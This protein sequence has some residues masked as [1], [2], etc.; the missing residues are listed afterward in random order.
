ME[1]THITIQD[2]LD[3]SNKDFLSIF[4]NS[5]DSNHQNETHVSNYFTETEFNEFLI[6]N[7]ISNES[8]LKILSL[9]IAN[10]LSKLNSLRLFLENISNES[11]KPNIIVVTETHL[12]KDKNHGYTE[13]DLEHL[14]PNY[15]FFHEDRKSKKGGGVGIFIEN[16]LIKQVSILQRNDFFVEEVFEGLTIKLPNLSFENGQKNLILLV[17]YRQPGNSN[18]KLF[19]ELLEKWLVNFDK[20]SNELVITGDMNLDLL[21]YQNH[22][23]T[24]EY[25]DLMA[26]H[27]LLP[28]ITYPTRLK[29]SSATL[30]DHIFQKLPCQAGII[31]TELA[32]SHGYTD[33]FPIFCVLK[34]KREVKEI[35]NVTIKYFTKEGH[36]QRQTSLKTENWDN[37]FQEK[38]PDTACQIFL[39]K[40]TKNYMANLTEKTFKS[41]SNKIPK[42]PWMSSDILK[43][44]RKR[45]RLSKMTHRRRDYL[46]LR[47]EITKDCRKAEKEYIKDKIKNNLNNTKEH[48][49]ILNNIMGKANNK[50][51]IPTT[52]HHQNRWTKDSQESAKFMNNFFSTIGLS[53]NQSVGPARHSAKHFLNKFMTRNDTAMEELEFT[54]EDVND[55]Y[56]QLN[57]KKSCD[58]Y[59]ISQ[60]V[61]LRDKNILL[62][63][64]LHLANCSFNSGK[65]P[66]LFKIARVVP[67]YK[68]KGDNSLFTNYRPI[69]LLP[70]F[71][72]ILEKMIYNKIFHFLVRYK[73]LFKSQYGFRKGHNTTHAT[74]DFLKIIEDALQQNEF[75]IGIFCDLSKAFD[76]LDHAV[77]LDKLEHYGIRG[78]WLTWIKSY[79]ANRK[80]YVDLNGEKSDTNDITVGVPQGSI[81]G[82][83]LFL[84]YI[85]DLPAALQETSAVMFADDTNLIIKG[86]DISRLNHSIN[87]DL[88]NLSD[89]FKANKLK[90]NVDKTKMVCFRKKCKKYDEKDLEVSLDNTSLQCENHATFLGM[91]LDSHLT[92]ESHC[93]NVANKMARSAGVLN[94][95]KN[96]LPINS[97]KILYHSLVASH[98]TYGLEAWGSCQ[99]RFSKRVT[100]IQKKA[101]RSVTKSHW[102]SHCE[103]R[104]KSLE[105]LAF[106]DQYKYQCA[107][108]VFNMLHGAGPDIYSLAEGQ[109]RNC[110]QSTRSTTLKPENLRLN[111]GSI[112][113]FSA[114]APEIWNSLSKEIQ[115]S[116]SKNQLKK[117]FKKQILDG[118]CEKID[119]RNPK[120]IDQK[121]HL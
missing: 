49:K 8:H 110:S 86:N 46:N 60:E 18:T 87:Q 36:N 72:K 20:R 15:L 23:A 70:A 100:I 25:L 58:A 26:L 52:F 79:L 5:D 121:H 43:K 53:T 71:S 22:A 89:Y 11:N 77:L 33:H 91:T 99:S 28:K 74:L 109:S 9:N 83:L 104:L 16:S 92:W 55:A 4:P 88:D 24:S 10:L 118:Y 98:F 35:P 85:N 113:G 38:D 13:Y 51:D 108:M 78:K 62:P 50:N 3:N 82:P 2:V 95:V 44:M 66:E 59:G 107:G 47:N 65:F 111:N 40:Y 114:L 115:E 21:K 29:H 56:A 81:L 17:L 31:S 116:K 12:Q 68:G 93:N 102:L 19:L 73:I 61:I 1:N 42:N 80:Q 120:C 32:G 94:R 63:M 34:L 76:T 112:K 6:Q 48:W 30:I 37:F 41:N 105:V 67:V 75:A 69:S 101:I 96:Y 45:D 90:L 106:D 57:S 54:N 14:L 119:C 103:P 84:L 117:L 27:G 7:H 64:I 97:M 39:D